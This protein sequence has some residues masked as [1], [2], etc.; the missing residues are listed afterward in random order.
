MRNS[1]EEK[2]NDLKSKNKKL[3]TKMKE[4][5][6]YQIDPEFVKNKLVELENC[7]KRYNLYIDGM[8][9][10]SN[11]IWEK[12]EKG[13]QI[14]FKDKP[15]IEENIITERTHRTNSAVEGGRSKPKS[16]F[17]KFHNCKNKVKLL[18]N[19]KKLAVREILTIA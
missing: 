7:C 13:L 3:K 12:C 15:G 19:A 14:L 9:V 10:T 2:V 18:H 1:L 8:K 4:L 16:I 11:E 6:E 17:C 5:Y